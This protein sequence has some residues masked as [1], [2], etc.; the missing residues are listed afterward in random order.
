MRGGSKTF[1]QINRM[2]EGEKQ[3]VTQ[4][5]GEKERKGNTHQQKERNR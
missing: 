2:R 3:T 4:T 1:I 5:E